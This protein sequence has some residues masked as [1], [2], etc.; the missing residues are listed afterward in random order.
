MTLHK[1]PHGRD[2][3]PLEYPIRLCCP[4]GERGEESLFCLR[5]VPLV[6]DNM[7][8]RRAQM[9]PF[10]HMLTTEPLN[11]DELPQ[12]TN[13]Y[14]EPNAG[15]KCSQLGDSTTAAVLDGTVRAMMGVETVDLIDLGPNTG[16]WAPLLLRML[17]GCFWRRLLLVCRRCG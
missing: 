11:D 6:R 5:K 14:Y 12:T 3:R 17:P 10:K 2:I 9:M 16:D 7:L 13:A 4:H 8:A 1:R 15:G